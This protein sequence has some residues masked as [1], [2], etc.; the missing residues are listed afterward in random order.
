MGFDISSVP[1]EPPEK[2][3]ERR[4]RRRSLLEGRH[5]D[6]NEP[7]G[8]WNVGTLQL[9]L[10]E[11]LILEGQRGVRHPRITDLIRSE[12]EGALSLFGR[13]S[14]TGY[15][16]QRAEL[17]TV[18]A[19]LRANFA[20]YDR[21]NVESVRS[22]VKQVLRQVESDFRKEGN[23][24]FAFEAITLAKRYDLPWPEWVHEFF[25]EA[26]AKI[27]EL[28]SGVSGRKS[29]SSE[30]ES[31]GRAF[32]FG[33]DGKG[34][35]GKFKA[36]SMMAFDRTVHRQITA[37]LEKGDKLDIA[38]DSVKSSLGVSRSKVVTSY[39]RTKKL[40]EE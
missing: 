5:P 32:G 40:T 24:V 23:P 33:A 27:M 29:Q 16:R 8:P 7:L 14:G 31:V 28:R 22:Y 34:G 1:P 20:A 35:T 19:A 2:E 10:S 38:Y 17:L 18:S 12:Y 6:T 25:G 26:A 3:A 13:R 15:A 4:R 11:H 36:A 21:R 39:Q 9:S 37:K 30:A